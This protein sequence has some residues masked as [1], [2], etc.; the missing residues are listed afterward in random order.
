MGEADV[1]VGCSMVD[2]YAKCGSMEGAQRVF[3]KMASQD[4]NTWTAMILGHVKRSQGQKTLEMFQQMQQEGVRP[5]FV[6]F[7]G[8][9]NANASL[10][11]LEEARHFHEQIIQSG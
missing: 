1:F 3:S 11:A 6:I 7:V 2:M 5:N 10:V 8:V 4:V 9:V